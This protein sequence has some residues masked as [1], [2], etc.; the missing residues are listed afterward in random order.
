MTV[1]LNFSSVVCRRGVGRGRWGGGGGRIP[2]YFCLKPVRVVLPFDDCI[3]VLCITLAFSQGHNGMRLLQL[4][5]KMVGYFCLRR[6]LVKMAKMDRLSI[7]SSSQTSSNNWTMLHRLRPDSDQV[8]CYRTVSFEQKQKSKVCGFFG[9]ISKCCH[10]Y[11]LINRKLRLRQSLA[12]PLP[13]Q[14]APTRQDVLQALQAAGGHE[15]GTSP[16]PLV[17]S[18]ETTSRWPSFVT[19]YNHFDLVH[20]NPLRSSVETV[21]FRQTTTRRE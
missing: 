18:T 19:F 17:S 4:N 7:Y 8:N 13:V 5:Y 1:I 11:L 3:A 12:F 14:R 2:G 10:V 16:R 15:D 6:V 20:Q 9:P 21:W